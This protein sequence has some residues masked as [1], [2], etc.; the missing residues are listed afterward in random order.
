MIA[1]IQSYNAVD[2]MKVIAAIM[3]VNLHIGMLNTYSMEID[4]YLKAICRIA[5]PFFFMTSGFFLYRKIN[6]NPNQERNLIRQ[7]IIRILKLYCFWF[8]ALLPLSVYTMSLEPEK[9]VLLQLWSIIRSILF[10]GAFLGSWY[11]NTT[12]IAALIVFFLSKKLSNFSILILGFILYIMCIFSSSYYGLIEHSKISEFIKGFE[13][14]FGPFYNTWPAGVFFFAVGKVFG[15]NEQN[16]K[17]K[18]KRNLL[19]Y[20]GMIIP[21]IFC[22]IENSLI[23][24]YELARA[25]DCYF[26]VIFLSIYLFY[27][28]LNTEIKIGLDGIF[29]KLRKASTIIFMS[30]SFWIFVGSR[31]LEKIISAKLD[32]ITK[33]LFVVLMSTLTAIVFVILSK[34][35]KAFQFSY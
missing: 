28:V 20:G 25:G 13:F 18:N 12:I 33:Y 6:R 8:L 32:S 31:L 19:L 15:E 16:I 21:I 4:Y 29:P 27:V 5:V 11:L 10:S 30:H 1:K 24:N 23:K 35:I 14:I 2:L 3:V 34:K 17:L 9:S 26:M 7:F 22:C